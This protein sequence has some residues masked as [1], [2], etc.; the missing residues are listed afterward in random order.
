M[1]NKIEKII[2]SYE[3]FIYFG[4]I[5]LYIIKLTLKFNLSF[6][7]FQSIIFQDRIS[8]YYLKVVELIYFHFM[9]LI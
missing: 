6:L 4:K 9:L 1:K 8:T 5:Y 2:P 3:S 7:N